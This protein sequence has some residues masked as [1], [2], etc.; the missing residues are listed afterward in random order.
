MEFELKV[1]V[2]V[3]TE[4]VRR[5][6]GD[7]SA[8]RILIGKGLENAIENGLQPYVETGQITDVKVMAL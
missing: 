6:A 1:R 2:T 4:A 8:T 5:C 7:D 3:D